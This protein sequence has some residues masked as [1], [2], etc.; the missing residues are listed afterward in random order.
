[1]LRSVIESEDKGEKDKKR[2]VNSLKGEKDYL[3][4]SPY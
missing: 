1:M 3:H 4:K 2:K